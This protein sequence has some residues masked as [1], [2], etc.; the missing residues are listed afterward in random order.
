MLA[1]I[2]AI[3]LLVFAAGVWWLLGGERM[4]RHAPR[5][6]QPR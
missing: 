1:L 6:G 4:A 2:P 5:G 3:P